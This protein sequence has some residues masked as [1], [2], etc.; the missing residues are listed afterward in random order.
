M[1]QQERFGIWEVC[2]KTEMVSLLFLTDWLT[3][4]I[5]VRKSQRKGVCYENYR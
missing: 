4:I 2:K 5:K 1:L 3:I